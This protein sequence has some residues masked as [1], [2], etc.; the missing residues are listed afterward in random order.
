MPQWRAPV[1]VGFVRGGGLSV[2]PDEVEELRTYWIGH[3]IWNGFDPPDSS[4]TVW[5]GGDIVEDGDQLILRFRAESSD[6]LLGVRFSNDPLPASGIAYLGEELATPH[7]WYLDR[8]IALGEALDTG[9]PGRARRERRE[10]FVELVVDATEWVGEPAPRRSLLT[11]IK[12]R[13]TR[14]HLDRGFTKF[15]AP[16]PRSGRPSTVPTGADPTPAE[17]ELAAWAMRTSHRPTVI[18]ETIVGDRAEVVLELEPG[19]D[20]WCYFVRHGGVWRPSH[21]GNAPAI[22]W[23]DPGQH[24]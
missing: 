5:I 8:R 9:L 7:E 2:T 10:G 21:S 15:T 23:S 11:T 4:V 12:D 3:A 20:E 14:R 16:G 19:Y 24:R 6:E 22:D 17:V 13:L 18:S 1:L